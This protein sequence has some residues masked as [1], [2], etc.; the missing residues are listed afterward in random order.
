M[1]FLSLECWEY[2]NGYQ[3]SLG[4]NSKTTIIANI[5]PSSWYYPYST[6]SFRLKLTLSFHLGII[7][8]HIGYSLSASVL[9]AV[10]HR[11]LSAPSNLHSGRNSFRTMWVVCTSS[12]HPSEQCVGSNSSPLT[13][14]ALDGQAVI[15]E[16]ATGDVK[17]LQ[18]QIQ[19]L[20]DELARVRRQSISRMPSLSPSEDNTPVDAS[21]DFFD[22][23]RSSTEG[24]FLQFGRAVLGPTA[25]NQKVVISF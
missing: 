21:K 9:R 11:R 5:S 7:H 8:S 17:G 22:P 3:D 13:Y 23:L 25:L 14:N 2:V 4:G 1:C 6:Y 10:L 15:N 18:E 24:S 12:V 16:E 20:K 19:Q